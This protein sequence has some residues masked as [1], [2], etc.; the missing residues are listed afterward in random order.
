[1]TIV[2]DIEIVGNRFLFCGLVLDTNEWIVIWGHDPRCIERLAAVM[3]SGATFVSFNGIKFDIQVIQAVLAGLPHETIKT[4]ANAIIELETPPWRIAQRY[5]FVN[6]KVDHLDLIEVAPGTYSSLKAYASRLHFPSLMDMPFDHRAELTEE[7]CQVLLTYCQNDVLI[8]TELY[9]SLEKEI[10]TRITMGTEYG[11]DLRSKSDSQMA[12]A[13]FVARL[14]LGN[15][16]SSVPYSVKYVMPSFI[17]FESDH[18]K[19]LAQKMQDHAYLVDTKTGHVLL[20]DFLAKEIVTINAGTYQIGIGGLHS[21]HDRK[22]CHVSGGDYIICDIDGVS[23][24]PT[25]ILACNLIPTNLG[26][27]FIDEYRLIYERRMQAKREGNKSVMDTL[28]IALNGTFGKT[29]SRWSPLYSPDLMITITLTG[30]LILMNLIEQVEL[31]GATVLSANTDGIAVGGGRA[32]M[33]KVW[34]AVKDFSARSKFE[35]EYT[36]YKTIAIANVNNYIAITT[37][38]KIKA[39]GLFATQTLMKNPTA[40]I[41]SHAVAQWLLNGTPFQDTIAEGKLESFISARSVTG[42]GKQGEQYLGRVVRWYNS[43]DTSLPPITYA[44]NGNKVAKTDG[45]RA[46]MVIDK[47]APLPADLD[48]AWYR[49]EAIKIA[50]NLGC[51]QFLTNEELAL[52]YIPPKVRKGKRA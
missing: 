21:T 13:I 15:R 52:V 48:Y 11:L 24:Y 20:P 16:K 28:R 31:A 14:K 42:G 4:I 47:T 49:K 9:R 12:E 39:K 7:Q 1:M 45:V 27:G 8:T 3:S 26:Q 33:M 22:V 6:L 5:N 18:L 50:Q 19:E 17:S 30:Q 40:Q 46:C 37:K 43:T 2:F 41:C 44:K 29:A 34:E 36:P 23:F 35:F 25:I 38:G 32:A 51:E 10:N